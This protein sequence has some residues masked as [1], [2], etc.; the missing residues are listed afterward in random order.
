MKNLLWG[1]IKNL[2]FP[3]WGGNWWNPRLIFTLDKP[4][5]KWKR[6]LLGAEEYEIWIWWWSWINLYSYSYL[7]CICFGIWFHLELEWL[8]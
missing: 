7:L 6:S 2:P 5:G 4:K 8:Y 1:K 3:T